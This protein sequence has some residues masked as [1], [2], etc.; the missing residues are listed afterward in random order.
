M[1]AM[2]TLDQLRESRRAFRAAIAD[3]TCGVS[4]AR[5][6][7]AFGRASTSRGWHVQGHLRDVTLLVYALSGY[8][9]DA[10]VCLLMRR[11]RQY[12]WRDLPHADVHEQLKDAPQTRHVGRAAEYEHVLTTSQ[13]DRQAV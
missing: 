13:K 2:T 3:A 11:A 6:A 9:A 1:L 7:G 8:N 10:A 4:A 5:R 12:G